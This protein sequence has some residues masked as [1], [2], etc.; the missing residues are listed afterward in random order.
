MATLEELMMQDAAASADTAYT[1]S[2]GDGFEG[3]LEGRFDEDWVRVELVAGKSYD[4]R[5]EGVGPDGVSR[6]RNM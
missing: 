6:F 2:V 1:L 5:L 4:I 3:Q